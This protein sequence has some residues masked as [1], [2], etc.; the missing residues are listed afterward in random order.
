MVLIV[1]HSRAL[2]A[3]CGCKSTSL[4]RRQAELHRDQR[5]LAGNSCAVSRLYLAVQV[6]LEPFHI[7]RKGEIPAGQKPT[8]AMRL[9][10]WQVRCIHGPF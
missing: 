8:Y 3:V 6:L 9:F 7:D 4:T 5:A 2:T 10:S 1:R